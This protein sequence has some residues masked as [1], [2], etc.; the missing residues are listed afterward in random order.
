MGQWQQNQE[1]LDV[2]EEPLVVADSPQQLVEGRTTLSSLEEFPDCVQLKG[3]EYV[4]SQKIPSEI[5]T[6]GIFK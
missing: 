2:V 1:D 4:A 6:T 5:P 3:C